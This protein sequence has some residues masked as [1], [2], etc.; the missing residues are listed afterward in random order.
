[1]IEA[2]PDGRQ[3]VSQVRG[4]LQLLQK[5]SPGQAA[6]LLLLAWLCFYVIPPSELGPLALSTPSPWR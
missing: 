6:G 2:D 3:L 1:V 5:R 4:I